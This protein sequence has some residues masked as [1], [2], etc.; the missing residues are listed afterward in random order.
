METDKEK[1]N[2]TNDGRVDS[3]GRDITKTVVNPTDTEKL[4][5]EAREEAEKLYPEHKMG[6]HIPYRNAYIKGAQFIINQ[7]NERKH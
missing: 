7:L 3:L 6:D 1:Y 5:S 2:S 4:L